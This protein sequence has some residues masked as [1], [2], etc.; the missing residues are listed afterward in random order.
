MYFDLWAEL[1]SFEQWQ[2]WCKRRPWILSGEYPGQIVQE[3]RQNGLLTEDSVSI[4]PEEVEIASDNYRETIVA[5]GVSSRLRALLMTLEVY[6]GLLGSSPS[7]YAPESLTSFAS[8][9]RERFPDFVGSE[10]LPT[11]ED[12]QQFPETLH[13]DV[14]A[15]TFEDA[16]FD[17][18]LSSE[19]A[20][21]VPSF[22]R[23]ISEARRILR[24]GGAMIATF[25]FAYDRREHIVKAS[26]VGGQVVYHMEPEYHGN[27][28]DPDGGSLVFT[29][30]G[31]NVLDDFRSAGFSQAKMVLVGSSKF[32][33]TGAEIPMII[34]LCAIA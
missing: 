17:L 9:L 34:L 10:Y 8:I 25:P 22:D 30:P 24:P 31:W 20:E 1:A 28:V 32:G 6:E 27:P 5:N 16:S 13:Q 11:D 4:P 26:L 12:R 18:Y 21:H 29:V 23:M 14:T 2:A 7:V 3:I 33:I 15:L 19:V